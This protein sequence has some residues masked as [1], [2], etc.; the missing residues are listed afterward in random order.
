MRPAKEMRN[1]AYL[2]RKCSSSQN[3]LPSDENVGSVLAME[4]PSSLDR[5]EHAL[6]HRQCDMQSQGEVKSGTVGTATYL[7]SS[8]PGREP[9]C[10][11]GY[12][13]WI[14]IC[15]SLWPVLSYVV[16]QA[17]FTSFGSAICNDIKSNW[18]RG[19]GLP[20]SL[21]LFPAPK[22]QQWGPKPG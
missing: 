3:P 13:G 18:A 17:T 16:L 22:S 4:S 6:C 21:Q 20:L 19:N 14:V 5:N 8:H 12:L 9:T 2:S 7:L 1:V 10:R 15:I 11:L